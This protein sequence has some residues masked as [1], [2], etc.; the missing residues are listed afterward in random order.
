MSSAGDR[1]ILNSIFNPL[2][3]VGECVYSEDIPRDLRGRLE[4]VL[5]FVG[6]VNP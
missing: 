2:L 3:P 4:L 6:N 5:L 1:A